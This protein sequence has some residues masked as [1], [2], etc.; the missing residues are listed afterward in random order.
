ML[1]V[2]ITSI[3]CSNHDR[4]EG[5][6]ITLAGWQSNPNEEQLLK[7]VLQNFVNKHPGIKVKYEVISDQYM[8][9]IKTRLIGDAAPDVFYLDAFEAPLLMKNDV[10]EPLDGYI[11]PEFDLD[12]FQPNLLN[13][14]RD[15]GKTYGLPK[16]FS[17]LAFL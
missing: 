10:L 14:F 3:G 13:A 15:G 16:D 17:T 12:D 5:I 9:I 1:L 8:D 7:Q 6:T 2:I 11:K 4:D